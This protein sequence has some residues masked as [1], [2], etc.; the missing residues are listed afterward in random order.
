MAVRHGPIQFIN[1]LDSGI[2]V[3]QFKNE[4]NVA[5][6]RGQGIVVGD[7]EVTN[8]VI[9]CKLPPVA[10]TSASYD[11]YTKFM[12]IV[13]NDSV[14]PGATG[15]ACWG[16]KLSSVN[17]VPGN[18]ITAGDILRLHQT[19]PGALALVTPS[20]TNK[21]W[22]IAVADETLAGDGSSVRVGRAMI[23][24]WRVS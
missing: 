7:S 22:G 11:P 6:N 1:K 2:F 14:K 9:P 15:V 12:G 13:V 24:P 18:T 10:S 21:G 5:L 20:E 23:L 3:F 17:M 16:G 8:V 4:G 19:I